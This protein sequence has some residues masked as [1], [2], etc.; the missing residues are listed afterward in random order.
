MP[1]YHEL[2]KNRSES[3]NNGLECVNDKQEFILRRLGYFYM[4][5]L[6]AICIAMDFLMK[7]M[8]HW[9]IYEKCWCRIQIQISFSFSSR[10]E[11]ELSNCKLRSRM[12][13]FGVCEIVKLQNAKRR[14]H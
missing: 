7:R 13:E 6:D 10:C 11:A 8:G 5:L 12:L 4:L 2:I 14:K 9:T 3:G 1:I